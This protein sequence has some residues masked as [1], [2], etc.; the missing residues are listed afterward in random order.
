MGGEE[1]GSRPGV[2]QQHARRQHAQ[3]DTDRRS[4][5]RLHAGGHRGLRRGNVS[6]Y[7]S[8]LLQPYCARCG[9]HS[10][11]HIGSTPMLSLLASFSCAMCN[12]SYSD[13][14]NT[15]HEQFPCFQNLPRVFAFFPAVL[16][17]CTFLCTRGC[18]CWRR[19]SET[20][21]ASTAK[22]P[23]A[24]PAKGRPL[25]R[26]RYLIDVLRTACLYAVEKHYLAPHQ[27]IF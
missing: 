22:P 8:P 16:L 13:R 3:G 9:L 12:R 20:L 14:S 15:F 25:E 5:R 2:V 21:P 6:N 19:L 4:R 26:A 7:F 23:L 11:M 10:N 17:A 24:L 18:C 1:H 27:T